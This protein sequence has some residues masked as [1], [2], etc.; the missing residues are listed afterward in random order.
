MEIR[1]AGHG[2]YNGGQLHYGRVEV[3]LPTSDSWGTVCDD[4]WDEADAR[5]VCRMLGFNTSAVTAFGRNFRSKGAG[6]IVITDVSCS[7]D[8]VS[9]GNCNYSTQTSY[10]NHNEDAGLSCAGSWCT[11][12]IFNVIGNNK[13]SSF[14]GLF[15]Y[16]NR[17]ASA[18]IT[19][20]SG[21]AG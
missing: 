12:K 9:L 3:K 20:I 16:A 7:G 2:T 19:V 5:V 14:S 6:K 18:F 17:L 11:S 13:K 8:E 4:K 15:K 21:S 1:L 10:C